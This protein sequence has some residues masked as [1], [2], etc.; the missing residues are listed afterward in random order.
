MSN[1]AVTD[2]GRGRFGYGERQAVH[3]VPADRGRFAFSTGGWTMTGTG[4]SDSLGGTLPGYHLSLRLQSLEPP[5]LHGDHGVVRPGSFG[6][7]SY[8]SFTDL[9]TTG[10]L[11]DHGVRL[12]VTG[13]SWMDH[14]WGRMQL[15]S[16]AGWD[17]FSIQLTDGEQYMCYFL[18]DRAGRIVQALGT[19]VGRAGYAALAPAGLA[20][21]TT[22]TWKSPA[23]GITY[24]SGWVLRVPGGHLT[25]RP[26]LAD[27]ELALAR[28][29]GNNYW[30]GDSTVTGVVGGKPVHG[31]GYTELNPPGQ[32]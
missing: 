30:E 25:V 7:A 11:V 5:A 14:E 8:Y 6:V 15:F 13:T 32:L 28:R 26:D 19:R 22:G 10:T 18:R 21:R 20:E 3:A 27:Q 12:T 31:V 16:G 29:Q 17:W 4:T 24:G 2:L 23:T 1:L 9:R